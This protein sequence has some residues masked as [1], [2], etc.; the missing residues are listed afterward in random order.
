MNNVRKHPAVKENVPG[1][2]YVANDCCTWCG[3]P[4]V[5]APA[6][7]G[8]V[9]QN[10]KRTHDQCFVKQQPQTP[11]QLDQMIDAMAVQEQGCIRY[12]GTDKRIQ[13]QIRDVNEEDQIDWKL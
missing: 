8:G 13:E 3:V 9:D 7:F 10:G 4:F 6:L 2:F 12:C 1:D 11:E 5:V